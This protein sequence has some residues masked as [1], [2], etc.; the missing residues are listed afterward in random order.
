MLKFI[1]IIIIYV[2]TNKYTDEIKR[3]NVCKTIQKNVAS[4]LKT[5]IEII[6]S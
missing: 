1:A 4:A 5:I 2:Y 3:K 6:I